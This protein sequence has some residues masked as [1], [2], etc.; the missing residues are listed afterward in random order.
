MVVEVCIVMCCSPSFGGARSL[1]GNSR[2]A[3]DTANIFG[4]EKLWNRD[5]AGQG[6]KEIVGLTLVVE[7]RTEELL[8]LGWGRLECGQ[9]AGERV[10]RQCGGVALAFVLREG[11]LD[12]LPSGQARVDC[13]RE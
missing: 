13:A 10:A 3:R 5:R 7:Q 12:R 11:L 2:G 6:T 9:L 1:R 8:H 4:R